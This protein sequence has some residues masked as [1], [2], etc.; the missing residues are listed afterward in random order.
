MA[1]ARTAPCHLK[2]WLID[3]VPPSSG[4]HAVWL[5]RGM[6]ADRLQVRVPTAHVPSQRAQGR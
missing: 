1:M 2:G 4:T 6:Q 3:S 5:D